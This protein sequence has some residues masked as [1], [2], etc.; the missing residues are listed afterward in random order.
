MSILPKAKEVKTKEKIY[1]LIEQEVVS[2]KM[3][4]FTN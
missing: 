4:R 3:P 1:Q 2:K